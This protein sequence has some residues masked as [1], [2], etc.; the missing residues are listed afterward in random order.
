MGFRKQ[1][2]SCE[3]VEQVKVLAD[4]PDDSSLIPMTH[5]MKAD[6]SWM[7]FSDLHTWTVACTLP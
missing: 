1:L 4:K 3:M 6:D 2:G 5:K 7:L